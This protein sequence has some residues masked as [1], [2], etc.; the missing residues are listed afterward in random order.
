MF[1]RQFVSIPIDSAKFVRSSRALGGAW[2]AGVATTMFFG[3]G[4]G[5]CSDVPLAA[6]PT[7]W[8]DQ[9]GDRGASVLARDYTQCSA[10]VEGRRSQLVACM[11]NFGWKTEAAGQQD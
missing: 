2:C 10:L 4:L 9:R 6:A 11:A 3:L 8:L 5:A 7:A 1:N